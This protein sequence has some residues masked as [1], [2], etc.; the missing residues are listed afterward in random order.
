M[1]K[2][3]IA[4]IEDQNYFEIV[5]EFYDGV[6]AL[7]YIQ[8]HKPDLAFIDVQL[9]GMNGLEV[10]QAAKQE[11]L[12]T[13]FIVISGHAEFAYAQKALFHNAISYCLKPFSRN[14]LMDSMQK[15]YQLLEKRTNVSPH[16]SPKRNPRMRLQI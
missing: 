7:S 16:H 9:P 3:L 13:L 14:E 5:G 2:S 8:E 10:L 11:N 15:A 1:I 4:T 6:S 12:S